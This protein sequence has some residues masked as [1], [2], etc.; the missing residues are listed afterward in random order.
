M[1]GARTSGEIRKMMKRIAAVILALGVLAG[2]AFAVEP[3]EMLKNPQ[4]E[5]RARAISEGL[6]CLVCQNESIDDST[7]PLAKDIRVLLRKRISAGDTDK[8]VI[9]FLVGRYGEFILLKPRFEMHTLVLWIAAPVAL[10]LGLIGILFAA[11]RRRGAGIAPKPLS[12]DEEK[13]LRKLLTEDDGA[14]N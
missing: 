10:I 3:D 13:E 2:P 1:S 7:A 12:A 5:A 11:R 9:D 6:R 8:Q 14:G 4:L